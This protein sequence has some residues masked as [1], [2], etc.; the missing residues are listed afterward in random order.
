MDLFQKCRDFTRPDQAMALGVYPYFHML[1]SGQNT[2]VIME[3]HRT[4]M[5]GSNNY[6]GLAN[7]PKVIEAAVRPSANTE[8]AHAA[9]ACLPER[10]ACIRNSRRS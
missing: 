5:L 10:P 9:H 2:E 1:T 8:R 3:G 6:L 4:I 7:H